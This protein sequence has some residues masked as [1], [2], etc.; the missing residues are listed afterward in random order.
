MTVS[1]L[2]LP[3]AV[4]V[5]TVEPGVEVAWFAALC[6]DDYEYLGVPDG[7]LRSNFSHCRSIAMAADRLGYS[8]ILLP[9][10]WQVGQDPVVFASGIAPQI[11]NMSL[12]VAIRSGEVFPPMLARAVAS[13]DH[14]LEG[15]LT[16]NVIS[17]DLPGTRLDSESRYRRSGEAIEILQQVWSQDHVHFDGEFWQLR[18]DTTD[19]AR[20]WQQNGGPLLYFGG[21]SEPARA[22]C[23]KHCDVYLMWPD[24]EEGLL[25]TMRDL[26]AR[27]AV[28]G[29]T[30]DF[31]LRIHVIVRETE[32]AAREA[33]KRLVSRLDSEVGTEIKHCAQ[34]ASSAGVLAQDARRAASE[35]DWIEDHVWS[36]IGRARSG[37]GSAVVGDPDQVLGRLKRYIDMGI[38]AF[39][40][41]GYPHLD[42]CR[43][44]AELVLPQLETVSL[45]RV[46]GRQPDT[47]P[48]TPL[49]T[50]AR[51]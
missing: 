36:G 33:A 4:T 3:D 18:I 6:S 29:R 9:S 2:T 10:S 43:R 23:A 46:H 44:F 26:S 35:D 51:R 19:P 22:L 17:P 48:T 24:T 12:L 1:P 14:M 28:H 5:R 16:L 40:L 27:A 11:R 38:R 41:S 30:L 39:I 13:L 47:P 45:P 20:T 32:T 34:D 25:A 50:G 49:T 31:G 7:A 37:C 8:N 15:R 21:Y 42:E